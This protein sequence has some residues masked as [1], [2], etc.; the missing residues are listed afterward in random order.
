MSTTQTCGVYVIEQVGPGILYIGSSHAIR[1]RWYKHRYDLNHGCHHS[2]W[3]QNAWNKHGPDAFEFYVLEECAP[4]NLLI[5]E[6]EYLDAFQP[7]FNVN[8]TARSRRGAKYSPELAERMRAK[9]RA[10]ADKI[11]HCPHGHPYDETNTYFGRKGERICRACNTARV[12]AVYEHETPEQYERRR[13]S[14]KAYHI[15]NR[16]SRLVKQREY[17]AA[18]KVEKAAYDRRRRLAGLGK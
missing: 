14:M 9:H 12:A 17:M 13:Q 5:R 10:R 18:H 7:A 6:Q 15:K 11:T 16:E 3:L 8:P 1:N 2:P 4:E